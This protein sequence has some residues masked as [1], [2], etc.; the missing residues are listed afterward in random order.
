MKYQSNCHIYVFNE[1]INNRKKIEFE[2]TYMRHCY[3]NIIKHHQ[4]T[5]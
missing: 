4:N 2:N 5:H 1:L 3:D